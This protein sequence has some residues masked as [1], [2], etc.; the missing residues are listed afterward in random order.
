MHKKHI[1]LL[2]ILL[3]CAYSGLYPQKSTA[4][5]AFDFSFT[6]MHD[7]KQY[8]TV[9]YRGKNMV[10]VFGSIYC[11][12]CV[13]LLPLLKNFYTKN[14]S[15]G[16]LVVGVDVDSTTEQEKIIK[17][18]SDQAINFPFFIDTQQIARKYKVF[19]LP[20]VIFI[21]EKGSISKKYCIGSRT[22]KSVEQELKK[23]E[24]QYAAFQNEAK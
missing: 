17:F 2:I 4:E 6:S 11:R 13:G 9:D 8:S 16:V 23:L 19:M 12:P 7:G 14:K 1:S 18:V 10:L 20:T 3:S 5:P 15:S 22:A 21:D 24:A